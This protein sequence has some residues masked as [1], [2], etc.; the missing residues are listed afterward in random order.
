M[1]DARVRLETRPAPG[2]RLD[3][4]VTSS[5]GAQQS[6]IELK[7]LTRAWVGEFGGEI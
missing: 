2:V 3:L 4:L 7:D 1:P 6:A 5:D